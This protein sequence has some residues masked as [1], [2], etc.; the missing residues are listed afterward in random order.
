MNAIQIRNFFS[1]PTDTELIE[2]MGFL[3]LISK[4]GD[5]RPVGDWLKKYEASDRFAYLNSEGKKMVFDKKEEIDVEF[6]NELDSCVNKMEM[7]DSFK[8]EEDESFIMKESDH[9]HNKW[10]LKMETVDI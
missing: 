10:G 1:D 9:S 4:F 6:I 7:N 3:V 8:V 5:V 2:L